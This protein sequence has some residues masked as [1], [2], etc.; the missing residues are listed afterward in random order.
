MCRANRLLL[1]ALHH[2]ENATTTGRVQLPEEIRDL[3]HQCIGAFMESYQGLSG[4]LLHGHDETKMFG[5]TL[6]VLE[7]WGI[8]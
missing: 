5:V 7:E 1:D 6:I 8:W 2:L 3:F 4:P